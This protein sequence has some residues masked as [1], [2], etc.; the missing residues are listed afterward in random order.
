MGS[1]KVARLFERTKTVCAGRFL[2]DLPDS[3][4]VS[5]APVIIRGFTISAF[6]ESSEAFSLRARSRETDLKVAKNVRGDSTLEKVSAVEQGT[7]VAKIFQFGRTTTPAIER[8]TPVSYV[9]V[10]LEGHAHVDGVTFLAK[11]DAVALEHD[12][13]LKEIISKLRAVPAG[14]PPE[15]PGFCFGAGMLEDP[16][17]VDWSEGLV[18]FAGSTQ[19]PDLALALRTRAGVKGEVGRLARNAQAD[20]DLLPWQKAQLKKIRRGERTAAGVSGDEVLERGRELNS[21]DVYAFDWEAVGTPDDVERPTIHLELSTGHPKQVGAGPVLSRFSED[22]LVEL[23]DRVL[24][25]LRRRPVAAEVPVAAALPTGHELGTCAEAGERCPATGWWRC[26]SGPEGTRVLHGA[27]QYLH[28]G[29]RLPQALLLP[30]QTL[31]ERFRGLQRSYE[32]ERRTVWALVDR[33]H[34]KRSE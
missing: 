9:N 23:W 24:V 8:G 1:Q 18:L 34:K 28:K 5:Y 4:E 32:E 29:R 25:T 22:D 33:R 17:P 6:R 30:P 12:A 27:C 21:V 14:G 3:M 2:L 13:A 10:A 7:L 20:E 19:Y 26:D 15:A 31:W 11:A 16:V